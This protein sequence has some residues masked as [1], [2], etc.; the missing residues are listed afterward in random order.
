MPHRRFA[1]P[2]RAAR[3][4]NTHGFCIP[5]CVRSKFPNVTKMVDATEGVEISV[6]PR[7][8]GRGSTPGDPSN[9]AMA[10]AFGRQHDADGAIIGLTRS[11]IVTGNTVTRL[12]TPTTVGREIT[13]FDRNADFAP[14]NYHLA[15]VSPAQRSGGRSKGPNS[16][17][18]RKTRVVHNSTV[19]VRALA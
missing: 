11:Y 4:G 12:V 2:K 14:G 3:T 10:C 15:P 7:D 6:T 17:S 19:R 13:S 16:R 8:C 18:G 1:T 9:C 5:T